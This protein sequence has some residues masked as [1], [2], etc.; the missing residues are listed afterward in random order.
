[1]MR[2]MSYNLSK[3]RQKNGEDQGVAVRALSFEENKRMNWK[4]EKND[5]KRE[6]DGSIR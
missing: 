5:Q 3:G 6:I 1:M 2:K 4:F